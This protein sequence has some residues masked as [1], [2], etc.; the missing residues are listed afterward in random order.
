[1]HLDRNVNG[2]VTLEAVVMHIHH[3][4]LP[5]FSHVGYEPFTT[6]L[7]AR[8]TPYSFIILSHGA[9]TDDP[10]VFVHAVLAHMIV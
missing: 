4:S 2:C 8:Q 1:M 10:G 5:H 6:D 3:S 9:D 7:F